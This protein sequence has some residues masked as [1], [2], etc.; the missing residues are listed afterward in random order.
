M[1][2]GKALV[3]GVPQPGPKS[4]WKADF[5]PG[6][7]ADVIGMRDMLRDHDFQVETLE[8]DDATH[9]AILDKIEG[10]ARTM[11]PGDFFVFVYSGHGGRTTDVNNDEQDGKDEL[12]LV[13]D[14]PI[15]DDDLARLWAKFK[16]GVR[17]VTM[18]DACHS[19]TMARTATQRG[20]HEFIQIESKPQAPLVGLSSFRSTKRSTRI[21]AGL[22]HISACQDSQL[23][24]DV[25]SGGAF[26]L[27][28]LAAMN[29]EPRNYRELHKKIDSRLKH[30]TQISQLMV[31]GEGGD[32]LSK[33]SPFNISLAS[34]KKVKELEK[35]IENLKSN[36][37]LLK[38][39]G[40]SLKTRSA[41]SSQGV[42]V[43]NPPKHRLDIVLDGGSIT[44]VRAKAYVLGLF[45]GVNP[46][47]AAGAIDDLLDGTIANFVSRRMFSAKV[48]EV[49][50]LPTGNAPIETDVVLFVGL[51]Q[52][53]QFQANSAEVQKFAAGN[54][55]RTLDQL[56]IDEFCTVLIGGGSGPEVTDTLSN[57]VS[58][59]FAGLRDVDLGERT[60]RVILCEYDSARYREM[61]EYV[62][63]SV[64]SNPPDGIQLT[65]F[66]RPASSPRRVRSTKSI[67]TT[68]SRLFLQVRHHPTDDCYESI[69]L[70]SGGKAT[71]ISSQHHYDVDDR[72]ELLKRVGKH[73]FK[74][75]E[76]GEEL[77]ELALSDEFVETLGEIGEGQHLVVIHDAE[78]SKLP[79]ET[80][81]CDGRTMALDGGMSRK[82]LLSGESSI[83]KW[84]EKRRLDEQLDILLVVNPTGD[85]D[86][87][88]RECDIIQGLIDDLP[89]VN[90]H[91]IR[92][93]AAT[94]E[95]LLQEFQSGNYD[96]VHY[97]GH[98]EFDKN[99][100]SQSGILCSDE[101]TLSGADLAVMGDLPALVFF[102]ACES[103]RVRSVP[104]TPKRLQQSVSFAEAFLR[105]GIANFIGTYW[106]V[107]D[108]SAEEFAK[109]FYRDVVNGSAIGDALK[110]GRG[111]VRET[112]SYD[113]ADY[114]HYG[115]P[116]FR[117]K[118]SD[119][120]GRPT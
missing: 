18:M 90:V 30:R 67:S 36:L 44:D 24:E 16:P 105:G 57:L 106:P 33:Q 97:A 94:R 100:V 68:R 103:G 86:G 89:S 93:K 14:T 69:L 119:K 3:V 116:D 29:E 88:E 34:K 70:T 58:G 115:D 2:N 53:D 4:N 64:R 111:A 91:T 77:A 78:S 107:G 8:K 95:R 52:L 7:H 22:V 120:N 102:N 55:V 45:E 50:M 56:G 92:G 98:A 6:V 66:E 75:D 43:T 20:G 101:K 117:I 15:S 113:W 74:V 96:I 82:Y 31:L 83:G 19:G 21:Q 118:I 28:F 47:G 59:F 32:N 109:T 25:G 17:I 39:G 62:Y 84:R 9:R 46:S 85:L 27:A 73:S 26:T 10:F 65:I 51:G 81:R 114:I 80:L 87:A 63:S 13:Y 5:L 79:W 1:A 108:E 48:G 11:K 37:A 35:S 60:R 76:F 38:R 23:A 42:V 72:D 12:L 41:S 49:F 112:G 61:V 40:S 104:K 71:A 110:N 54:V 99:D